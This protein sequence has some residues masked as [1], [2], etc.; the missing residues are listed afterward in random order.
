MYDPRV[1]KLIDIIRQLTET[2]KEM[3][4]VSLRLQEQID[5]QQKQ[6]NALSNTK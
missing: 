2:A 4:N 5:L 6:I 3:N 1:D